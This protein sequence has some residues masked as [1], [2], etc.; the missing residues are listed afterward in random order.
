MNR[1]IHFE[2]HSTDPLR[3]AKFYG[4]VFGWEISEWEIPGVQLP[5]EYRYWNVTTG[6]GS[7]GINGGL[8]FRRGQ[9]PVPGQDANAFVCT[10]EVE[11]LDGMV[12][13]AVAAGAVVATPKMPIRGV[14]WLAYLTDPDG[15]TFGLM[16]EDSGAR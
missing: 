13:K 11:S 2:I 12:E 15:N 4:D 16:Q 8:V 14:G 3:A 5:D 1:V 10:I 7:S 6:S 9:G